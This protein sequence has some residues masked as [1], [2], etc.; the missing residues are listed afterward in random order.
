M[1]NEKLIKRVIEN[2]I[3]N[4]IKYSVGKTNI[5]LE[6]NMGHVVLYTSN[7]VLN[8][9]ENVNSIFDGFYNGDMSRTN[10]TGI[11]LA[12]AIEVYGKNGWRNK[13]RCIYAKLT[14]NL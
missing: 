8:V 4:M 3:V 1:T 5:K 12:I 13:C 10:A 7:A 11:G 6:Y 9:K 2:L 14:T